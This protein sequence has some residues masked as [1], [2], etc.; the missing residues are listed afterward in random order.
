[1]ILNVPLPEF[2]HRFRDIV[3]N[4]GAENGTCVVGGVQ[5]PVFDELGVWRASEYSTLRVSFA[6]LMTIRN[7]SLYRFAV[8]PKLVPKI[9]LLYGSFA[10]SAAAEIRGLTT[11]KRENP[12]TE[13]GI[14]VLLLRIMKTQFVPCAHG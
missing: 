14:L 6:Y 10:M 2:R 13:Q 3:L 5:V 9:G 12:K 11:A 7:A 4:D 1:V 8:R